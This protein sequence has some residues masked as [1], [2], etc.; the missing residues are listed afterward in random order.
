MWR[1]FYLEVFS[2]SKHLFFSLI[3]YLSEQTC[4]L[5]LYFTLTLHVNMEEKEELKGEEKKRKRMRAIAI[6]SLLRTWSS[7]DR[8]ILTMMMVPMMMM[9][10]SGK[11]I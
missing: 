2:N 4:I 6:A 1:F 3:K 5:S 11:R 10:Q 8:M 9:M 7:R